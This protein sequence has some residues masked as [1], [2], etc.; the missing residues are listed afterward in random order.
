LELFT[1]FQLRD[2]SLLFDVIKKDNREDC[3]GLLVICSV[4]SD[5]VIPGYL[6]EKIDV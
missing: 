2:L 1:P 3:N 4:Q 6:M 5:A